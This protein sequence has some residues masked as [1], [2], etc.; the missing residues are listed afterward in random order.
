[1]PA[2][3]RRLINQ[4]E[5]ILARVEGWPRKSFHSDQVV[6]LFLDFMDSWAMVIYATQRPV[7]RR[8]LKLSLSM[9]ALRMDFCSRITGG[10]SEL[11][12]FSSVANPSIYQETSLIQ[13]ISKN[14]WTLK[15]VAMI[16]QTPIVR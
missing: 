6:R 10:F 9:L 11:F 1:M 12:N 13:K 7:L 14:T 8:I 4:D 2:G 3:L 5:S 15:H 16:M